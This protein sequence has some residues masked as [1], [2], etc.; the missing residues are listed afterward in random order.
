[1]HDLGLS[2]QGADGGGGMQSH[3][4]FSG[5]A[6]QAHRP[7]ADMAEA[8]PIGQI[9]LHGLMRL[10]RGIAEVVVGCIDG[11][12]RLGHPALSGLA[13]KVSGVAEPGGPCAANDLACEHGTF[14]AG[15][16]FADRDSAAPAICPDCTPLILPI[17]R[18]QPATTD[19]GL[20]STPQM[21]AKAIADC[22]DAGARVINVS[23]ALFKPSLQATAELLSALDHAYGRG[24]LVVVAAGNQGAVGGTA[25]TAHPAVIP[26]VAFGLDGRPM[27][28]SNLGLSIGRRGLGGPG[29]GVTSLGA[30]QLHTTAGGTSAAAPFVA[31][32]IALLWS[33][34][35]GLSAPQ[36]RKAIA[37]T[38]AQQRRSSVV[39]PL[40][41]ADAA[42]R[43][44]AAAWAAHA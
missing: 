34:F 1:V 37:A 16:L 44:A 38:S 7:Q 14:V 30:S 24:S 8:D 6:T 28:S 20:G 26:V 5:S 39:P 42:H 3:T 36:V 9:R 17:F 12:V 29:Q 41:D 27:A 13:R 35:P 18:D 10:T 33:L 15:V 2:F 11:P 23:A 4:S 19:D 43:H 31:G 32:T 21:L 22:V 40:I 25:M